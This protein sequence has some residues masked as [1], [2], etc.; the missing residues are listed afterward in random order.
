MGYY[1]FRGLN[2][3]Y[4]KNM[5][6][7]LFILVLVSLYATYEQTRKYNECQDTIILLRKSNIECIEFTLRQDSIMNRLRNGQWTLKNF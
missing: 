5:K 7:A 6:L 4:T 2:K 3:I 1:I